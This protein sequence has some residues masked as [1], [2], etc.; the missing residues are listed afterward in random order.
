[1]SM[2][3]RTISKKKKGI[4]SSAAIFRTADGCSAVR[5]SFGA[6]SFPLEHLPQRKIRFLSRN[7]GSNFQQGSESESRPFSKP[8]IFYAIQLNLISVTYYYDACS[9]PRSH[10]AGVFSGTLS[11]P[12]IGEFI[13]VWMC[14]SNMLTSI[15]SVFI[16]NAKI[17]TSTQHRG[18]H[19]LCWYGIS[20]THVACIKFLCAPK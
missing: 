20:R 8:S 3:E 15:A 17:T 19:H 10:A 7:G 1:M 13:R 2:R 18:I 9:Y 14:T 11:N 6:T 4:R 16:S 12:H 5:I